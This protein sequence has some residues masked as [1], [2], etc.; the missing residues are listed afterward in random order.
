MGS[1]II[2]NSSNPNSLTLVPSFSVTV[3]GIVYYYVDGTNTIQYLVMGLKPTND[4]N[5]NWNYSVDSI[6]GGG[7]VA[8]GSLSAGQTVHI[9]DSNSCDGHYFD[10]VRFTVWNGTVSLVGS[11]DLYYL[12]ATENTAPATFAVSIY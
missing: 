1:P 5:D 6:C 12:G 8:S 4:C 2:P 10:N 3:A 7:N 11:Q 9:N